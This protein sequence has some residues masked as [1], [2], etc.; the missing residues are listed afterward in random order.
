MSINNRIPENTN[1]IQ[2]TKFLLTFDRI[3]AVTYFCQTVRL[4]GV[5]MGQAPFNTP[6]LDIQSPG[7]KLSF[8]PFS[9]DFIVDEEMIGWRQIYEWFNS[10]ASPKGLEHR[11]ALSELQNEYKKSKLLSYSDA[12]LTIVSAL[13]NPIVRIQFY[14]VFPTSLSDINF[15]T[16][17][18]ADNIITSEVSFVYDYFEFLPIN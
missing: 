7:N 5:S 8:N 17:Q 4:P 15:D 16:T 11:K 1:P 6:L 14:N 2:P 13:N 18:S 9:V 3:G 12:T 10:M